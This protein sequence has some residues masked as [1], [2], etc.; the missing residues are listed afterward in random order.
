[1]GHGSVNTYPMEDYVIRQD[2]LSSRR[3]IYGSKQYVARALCLDRKVY[4]LIGNLMIS[5]R[6]S[7]ETID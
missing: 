3:K 6:G 5:K 1:M 7:I 4:K 2:S